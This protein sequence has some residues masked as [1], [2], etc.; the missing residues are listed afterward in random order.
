MINKIIKHKII[1]SFII[2]IISFNNVLANI[3]SDSIIS[4]DDM[5]AG[6]WQVISGEKSML[7]YNDQID[8]SKNAI[9]KL[10]EGN[11]LYN[12]GLKFLRNKEYKKA[13]ETFTESLKKYKRAKLSEH[14][15]NYIYINMA[16]SYAS[17][18]NDKDNAAAQRLLT[19]ITSKI[20]KEKEW[21]YNLSIAYHLI[22]NNAKAVENLS[23]AIRLDVNY[24]QAYITLESI[25]RNNLNDKRNADKV[26]DKM[27]TAEAKLMKKNQ[28]KSRNPKS[29]DKE[30]KETVVSITG[31]KPNIRDL[32]IMRNDDNLQYNK[33][34]LLNDRSMKSIQEGIDL[35][36]KGVLDLSKN[37]Y[38]Q[39]AENLKLAE[40]KLKK[41][42]VTENGLNFSR[43]N[44]AISYLCLAEETGETNKLGQ[45]KR[46]LGK[47]TN[48]LYDS[49]DVNRNRDWAYNLAVA[50]YNYGSKARGD[51]KTIFIKESVKLMKLSIKFDKLFLTP[52]QNLIY[53]YKEMGENKKAEKHQELFNKNREDLL[54][55]ADGTTD[56]FDREGVIYRI[57]L[58]K[59]G[60][61]EAPADLFDEDN[62]ITIPVN[63]R[64]TEYLAGMFIKFID[65]KKYLNEMKDRGYKHASIR[66]F[67]DG[68]NIP[69]F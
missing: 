58:G 39:A 44:L 36:N 67:K 33:V 3:V 48:K 51:A 12:S 46:L 4:T 37:N 64:Y 17:M 54:R 56:G 55:S 2:C 40:S 61:Y 35:Y 41:G 27:E 1:I 38:L 43:A 23:K 25:Y 9:K 24:F 31:I 62:I 6:E 50:Y 13:I 60:E 63:E 66:A 16:L 20:E 42:K 21:L 52:Y 34:S 15:Y 14:A 47:I 11:D 68:R 57:Y 29:K 26:R 10:S 59:F 32:D 69:L 22:G 18:N 28:K 53:I 45:V 30:H 7:K 65:A 5:I 19:F 49:D 8:R